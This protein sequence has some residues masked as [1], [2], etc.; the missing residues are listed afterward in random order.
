MKTNHKI[1]FG[2]S[3]NLAIIPSGTVDLMITSPPYPMIEMW[4]KMFG[5]QNPQIKDA[6]NKEDGE[7]AFE[8][9]NQELD[10]VWNEV[11]RVLKEGGIACINIGDATRT[12]NGRFQLFPS[13]S[14]I[15]SQCLKIGFHSLPE[16]LWRKQTNVPNKFM[17][18]GMLP[19][20]A[21]VTLEH[22]YILIFRKAG[23]R[24]FSNYHEKINR[25]KSSFFWE[26]RNVWFSDIWE[27]LKGTGQKLTDER[28]RDRSAAY[29]FELA[30]RLINMFSVK[31]D[32][33][34]DPYL[35]TGTTIVA[36]MVSGRNSI[37]AEID[38]NFKD[39][40]YSK[41]NQIVDFGNNYNKKRLDKHL[42]F[43][44]ERAKTKGEFKYENKVYKFPVMTKQELE[45]IF[46]N[47]T[48]VKKVEENLFEAY[49]EAHPNKS[50]VIEN[51]AANKK[52]TEPIIEK[53]KEEIKLSSEDE[54]KIK[55]IMEKNSGLISREGAIKVLMHQKNN[56]K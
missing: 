50:V 2:N 41:C 38:P 29:P 27:G 49:Y 34:L 10:K 20:G 11:Y 54:E 9:M 30:Y 14:R 28:I 46:H 12:I 5:E 16:I 13:H 18:S 56:S 45:L 22:E 53:E 26:E 21:Y 37:G 23:K 40:I 52:R 36:A 1:I 39:T 35:G 15:V 32:T 7:L 42:Q 24:D 43:I 47:L 48:E 4:D 3:N 55:E 33:I 17:G 8:L 44:E 25:Q 31:G 51:S 19:P 6:L